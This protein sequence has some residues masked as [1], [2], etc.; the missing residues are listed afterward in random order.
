MLKKHLTSRLLPVLLITGTASGLIGCS[1]NETSS[2]SLGS[3]VAIEFETIDKAIVEDS[4]TTTNYKAIA[5]LG[6]SSLVDNL[7]V[8]SA[9]LGHEEDLGK[10]LNI[11]SANGTFSCDIGSISLSQDDYRRAVFNACQIGTTLY[12]GELWT[13]VTEHCDEQSSEVTKTFTIGYKDYKQRQKLNNSSSYSQVYTNGEYVFTSLHELDS[14]EISDSNACPRGSELSSKVVFNPQEFTQVEEDESETVI[15]NASY[16]FQPDLGYVEY[17]SLELMEDVPNSSEF[18]ISGSINMNSLG[19]DIAI[20]GTDF[21]YNKEGITTTGTLKLT[22]SNSEIT[23]AF[24]A[25]SVEISFDENTTIP[26]PADAS[27]TIAQEDF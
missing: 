14:E 13:S 3:L 2:T 11:F 27:E 16:E 25:Q 10:F 6:Y 24:S 19:R 8:R 21:K 23:L 20:T 15:T 17:E 22:K 1:G 18:D 7:D 9:F 26:G 5:L 4:W 12:D